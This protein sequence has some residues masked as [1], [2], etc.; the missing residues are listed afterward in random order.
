MRVCEVVLTRWIGRRTAIEPPVQS[1]QVEAC[2]DPN[3]GARPEAKVLRSVA[4]WP[5]QPTSTP[6]CTYALVLV[7]ESEFEV[8]YLYTFNG[9]VFVFNSSGPPYLCVHVYRPLS[10]RRGQ[11]RTR[12]RR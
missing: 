12:W 11:L 3:P 5:W 10:R 7:S 1:R 9:S 8:N 6:M 2:L 4:T